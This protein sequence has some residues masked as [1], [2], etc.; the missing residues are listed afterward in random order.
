MRDIRNMT[1][2]EVKEECLRSVK[3]ADEYNKDRKVGMIGCEDKCR[4]K[5][6]KHKI[7][8]YPGQMILWMG[9]EQENERDELRK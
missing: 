3:S 4:L 5:C 8:W 2:L 9:D 6:R 7:G 1:L